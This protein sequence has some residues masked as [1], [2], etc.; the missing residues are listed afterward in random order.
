LRE[1]P[2]RARA[3]AGKLRMGCQRVADTMADMAPAPDDEDQRGEPAHE[4]SS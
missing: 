4:A 3:E 1:E 2:I